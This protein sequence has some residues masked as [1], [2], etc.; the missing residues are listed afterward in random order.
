MK[1]R[2]VDCVIERRLLLNFRVDPDQVER[3]LPVGLRPMLVGDVAVAGICLIRLGHLRPRGLPSAFGLR[4]ENVAHRFA[5]EWDDRGAT[6][7]GVYVPRRDSSS[8]LSTFAGGRLFPGSHLRATIKT[9]ETDHDIEISIRNRAEPMSIDVSTTDSRV[10]GGTLFNS[11][12]DAVQFFRNGAQGF[13]PSLSG[14]C[15]EGVQLKCDRWEAQPVDVHEIRSSFFDSPTNFQPG[16]IEFD[17]G[18]V[19]R[20]LPVRWQATG[21]RRF[22]ETSLSH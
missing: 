21:N 1:I 12:N 10:L 5:V 20:N 3:H 11:L 13:S 14:T 17:S 15:L 6:R 9:R 8:A 4:T 16:S 18:L 2:N 7:F 19:M 22:E